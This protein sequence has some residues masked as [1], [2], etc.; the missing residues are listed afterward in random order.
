MKRFRATLET[1]VSKGVDKAQAQFHT[2]D[3]RRRRIADD[4]GCRS[5]LVNDT[6]RWP[7]V[8]SDGKA[9][10]DGGYGG[11]NPSLKPGALLA[12]PASVSIQS[13]GLQ[14]VP[15]RMLA[16]TLQH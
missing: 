1:G 10:L 12:L 2:E 15:A 9:A 11:T 4:A 7:A 16:W 5:R 14:T 13:L 8:V 6:F 3:E